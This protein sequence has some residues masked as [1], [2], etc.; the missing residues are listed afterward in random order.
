MPYRSYYKLIASSQAAAAVK[1]K[2]KVCDD[3]IAIIKK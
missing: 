2:K 1:I 3:G